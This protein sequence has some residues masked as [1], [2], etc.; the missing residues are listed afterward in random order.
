MIFFNSI[1]KKIE[2]FAFSGTEG[3]TSFSDIRYIKLVNYGCLISTATLLFFNLT[4]AIADFQELW[5]LIIVYDIAIP[6]V[7]ISFYLNKN[8]HHNQAKL[9]LNFS[10]IIPTFIGT[11][12]FLAQKQEFM[13]IF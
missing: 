3:F 7:F 1:I 2:K 5:P 9:L 12:F 8:H 11:A 10:I 6:F 13:F 4:Y